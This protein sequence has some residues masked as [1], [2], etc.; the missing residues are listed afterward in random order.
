MAISSQKACTMQRVS[1]QI[2]LNASA[3]MSGQLSS[4]PSRARGAGTSENCKTMTVI[5]DLRFRNVSVCVESFSESLQR[6]VGAC[7]KLSSK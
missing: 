5:P 2:S 4:Y 3:P 6:H 1:E 7:S